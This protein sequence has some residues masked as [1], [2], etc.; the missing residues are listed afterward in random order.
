[1]SAWLTIVGVGPEGVPGLV[2][3]TRALLEAA[4]V[5]VGPDRMLSDL[6]LR[7]AEI[8]AWS[9][10]IDNTLKQIEDWKGRNVIILATGDPMHFGIGATIARRIAP[11]EMTIIP[12]PSAFSLA[13]ARLKW[14]LQ[15]VAT[16]SLHG[17]PV[18]TL[19]PFVHQG[20]NLIV[21]TT[22]G[23]TVLEV[24]ALLIA[25]G[26]G[27]S[28][29]SVLEHMGTAEERIVRTLADQCADHEFA[30]FNT[31]AIECVAAPDARVL[32]RI[33]GLPDEAFINDGQ[34]TKREVRAVTLSALAPSPGALLW[35]VGAG[36]G[37]VAI[38]W[39]R[40]AHGA[41]AIAFERHEERIRMIA[42]NAVA[43]G[44]PDLDIVSGDVANSLSG[45]PAPSAVF[46]GGAVTNDDVFARCWDAL[47]LGGRLVANAVTLEGNTI[48]IAR[49][50][51]HG[52]ELL[53]IDVSH[54][55]PVGA[56]RAMRPRMSVLQWRVQKV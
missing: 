9:S 4:E 20:A 54:V 38:E 30:D 45:H 12:A 42:E 2:S 7:S 29:L 8:H 50:E 33:P 36:C 53:R 27:Q 24:A 47:V 14:P 43:L 21:L 40:A 13:A 52:G 32:P 49:H 39:M 55:S 34:L 16:L 11:D 25:R 48:L 28:K 6:S 3:S 15:D 44:A 1:M 51:R 31:L 37:S 23:E 35:D 5:V 22:G 18:S 41:R 26:Y 56:R 46:V 19:Q 10:P 17:R